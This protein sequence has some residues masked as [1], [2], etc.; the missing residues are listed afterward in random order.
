MTG[1]KVVL[2]PFPPPSTQFEITSEADTLL[3]QDLQV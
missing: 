3:Y 1:G 2:Q